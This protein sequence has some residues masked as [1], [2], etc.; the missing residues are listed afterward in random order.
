MIPAD[1][2][3][4]LRL[5]TEASFFEAKQPI[6][7]PNRVRAI[8]SDVLQPGRT[9]AQTE[10][11]AP[12]ALSQI[13]R[14]IGALLT[15][16]PISG[17][18][19]L[20]AG[21][22]LLAAPPNSAEPLALALQEAVIHSGLFYE[23]HLAQWLAGKR[24]ATDLL[25]EPQAQV[26]A[27]H[28]GAI[29]ERLLPLVRQQLDALATHQYAWRAQPWPGQSIDWC[30]AE[31]SDD[32]EAAHHGEAPCWNSTLRLVL[33]R[34]GPVQAHL[35]FSPEGLSVRLLAQEPAAR[36][37]LTANREALGLSLGVARI[38]LLD[39]S[40]DTADGPI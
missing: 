22:P 23:A 26:E 4:R 19:A 29:P 18:A 6:Q 31:P 20:A 21:R 14:L 15:G 34:L 27:P 8:P 32:S 39:L 33:P 11:D 36:A 2:A 5:L 40:V 37:E 1:L 24:G 30:I 16:Q 12:P 28:D 10:T 25:K 13:G 9:R 7:Q 35:S 3:A 17:P 38:P